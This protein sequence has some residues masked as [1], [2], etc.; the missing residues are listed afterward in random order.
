MKTFMETLGKNRVRGIIA[1]FALLALIYGC[2]PGFPIVTEEQQDLIDKVDHT[3]KKTQ[4]LETRLTTL[5]G[6][7]ADKAGMEEL[8]LR[9][10]ETTKAVEDMG[11]E[12]SFIRGSIE[13]SGNAI[14]QSR[15]EIS[16]LEEN[17]RGLNERLRALEA[18]STKNITDLSTLKESIKTANTQ[19][20]ALATELSALKDT[21]SRP[22][23]MNALAPKDGSAEVTAPVAEKVEKPLTKTSETSEKPLKKGDPEAL[24]FKGFKL[25]KD[26]ELDKATEVFKRFLSLY[27]R[28]KLADHARYWLGEIYY[29]KGNWERAILEFDRVIKEYPGGDKVPAA[30]LK[31]AFSF[32]R[33]GSQKEARLLL[34][35]LIQKYP[36]S[37]EAKM[38][39]KR[40]EEL[41]K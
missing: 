9:L 21:L 18:A 14:A 17:A 7:G 6:R 10:A 31:E 28:N 24:Y 33:L 36:Q 11:R 38:A 15:S 41:K 19:I 39:Q 26:K 13:E 22:A 8:K 23:D 25:T 1:S 32:D 34:E 30:I 29:S 4:D 3:S 2:G 35:R 27:P 12:F 5:E 16:S 37:I 20:A 40:L